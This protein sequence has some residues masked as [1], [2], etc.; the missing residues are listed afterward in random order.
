MTTYQGIAAVTQTLSYL[1]GSAVRA[2]V[3]EATVTLSPPEVQPAAA[4]DVPRLNIY[5]VQVLPESAMRSADLPMRT[6]SGQLTTPPQV[7]LRLR[8]LFSFFG[9]TPGA[10][11]MLGAAEIA[12][13][14]HGILDAALIGQA[15]AGHP[16]LTG[17]GL[18]DQAPP[19]TVSPSMITLEEL[20]RFWSGFFQAPY[21]LSTL[22][23]A[24]VVL[25]TSPLPGTG[26]GLPVLTVNLGLDLDPGLPAPALGGFAP[27]TFAPGAP[28]PVTGTGVRAGQFLQIGDTWV[29][30]EPAAGGTLS[31]RLP[32][33]A[34]AGVTLTRLGQAPGAAGESVATGVPGPVTGQPVPPAPVPAA[35][36][37]PGSA[38]QLLV[39]QPVLSQLS[40]DQATSE[41]AVIIDPPP[42]AGQRVA[43]TL[44]NP[45][46]AGDGAAPIRLGP[47]VAVS[48]QPG[49][50]RFALPS[51]APPPQ[52]SYLGLVE[53][54]GVSSVPALAGGRFA[55]PQVTL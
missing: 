34:R 19:V 1:V 9:P 3:P 30:I 37:V 35:V 29:P 38:P 15:L 42:A 47:V 28:I 6:A 11:L 17:S 50:L 20:S 43:L 26:P 39:I 46:A 27:V 12:L 24:S 8:Y 54:D 36:P 4:R 16:E 41:V 21:T 44:V 7:A 33:D 32:A 10:Q 22:Y 53:V 13:R 52:G 51:G 55:L 18:E 23:E 2:V 14:E 48:A 5:L 31:A 45:T 49:T 40:L 25:L